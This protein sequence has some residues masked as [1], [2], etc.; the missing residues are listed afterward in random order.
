MHPNYEFLDANVVA[1][2][3]LFVFSIVPAAIVAIGVGIVQ[4]DLRF[5]S[6]CISFLCW[7]QR[8]LRDEWCYIAF[9]VRSGAFRVLCRVG[10]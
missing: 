1:V 6:F 10:I 3:L 4:N 2:R 7:A 5:G 9:V 8:P